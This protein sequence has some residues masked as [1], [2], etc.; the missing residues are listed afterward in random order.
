MI[1]SCAKILAEVS[2]LD[3]SAVYKRITPRAEEGLKAVKD[4]YDVI[5]AR[6][7]D[8]LRETVV[9][10]STLLNRS[11]YSIQEALLGDN[12]RQVAVNIQGV[13]VLLQKKYERHT[14]GCE[15]KSSYGL[16]PPKTHISMRGRA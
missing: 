13:R 6:S 15:D 3:R 14:F 10:C 11:L 16:R 12:G 4:L 2:R 5:R 9:F 1:Y 7:I 8:D